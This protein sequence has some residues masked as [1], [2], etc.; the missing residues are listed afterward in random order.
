M[1]SRAYFDS[2]VLVK[3]YVNERASTLARGLLRRFRVVFCV[4]T[5]LEG[6]SA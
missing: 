2:S 4:L 3:R 6:L 5:P 1:A